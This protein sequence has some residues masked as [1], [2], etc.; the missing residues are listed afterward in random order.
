MPSLFSVLLIL[1]IAGGT[2]GLI[3]GTLAASVKKGG[4]LHKASGL[5][6]FWGMFIASLAAFVLSNLPGHENIFLFAVGGFTIFMISS[7]YRIVHLKRAA[8][9]NEKPFKLIDYAILFFGFS[10]GFAL[11]YMGIRAII[12]GNNFGIVPIVFGLICINFARHDYG[13]LFGKLTV[14][15]V[16]MRSH[17]VRMMGAMIASYTAFLVVNVPFQPNW[18][19]WLTPTVIGSMLITYFVRKY[20]PVRK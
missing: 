8:R 4:K 10:F 7:G 5:V 18:V 2:A 16:W 17:I 20:V 11:I 1:H 13:M 9:Q 15:S 19:L 3:S 12:G 14:Q 6:F